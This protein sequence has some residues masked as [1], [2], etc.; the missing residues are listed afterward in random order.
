MAAI[1]PALRVDAPDTKLSRYFLPYQVRWINDA[2]PMCLAEKSVRIGWTFADALKNVRKRLLHK[3]RDYLFATKDEASAVEYMRT[4]QRHADLFN[5]S[6]NQLS[7][8]EKIFPRSE[9]DVAQDYFSLR[10]I[11]SGKRWVFTEGRNLLNAASHCDIAWAGAL[12]SQA[13]LNAPPCGEI[14]LFPN[15]RMSQIVLARQVR[16]LDG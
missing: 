2:S 10:K 4:V 5:F 15:T 14:Y 9:P 7:V 12:A 16:A 8:A 13:D 11:Y 6:K 1:L 3:N